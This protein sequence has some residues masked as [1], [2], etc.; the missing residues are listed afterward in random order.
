M[1][2]E[3]MPKIERHWCFDC[4]EIG[5][6]GPDLCCPHCGSRQ[7]Y[8]RFGSQVT[9][10][11]RDEVLMISAVA[12]DCRRIRIDPQPVL[13]GLARILNHDFPIKAGE[14]PAA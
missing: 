7:E 1:E 5:N 6:F 2:R 11:K 4:H 9:L 8:I 13:Q 14:V 12:A 10:A 3:N